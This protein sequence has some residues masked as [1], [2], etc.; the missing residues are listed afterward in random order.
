MHIQFHWV[1]VKSKKI[2]EALIWQDF[3]EWDQVA[4]PKPVVSFLE[5]TDWSTLRSL[6]KT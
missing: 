6:A 3:Q 2:K 1:L 5:G 4:V